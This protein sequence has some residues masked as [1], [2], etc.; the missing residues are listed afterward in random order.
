MWVIAEARLP[1]PITGGVSKTKAYRKIV[2]TDGA[3][4]FVL[5]QLPD[6]GFK[7]WVRGYGLRDSKKVGARP[8]DEL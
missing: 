7:V 3:G 8:G 2:V 1:N 6:K 4:R 5:P